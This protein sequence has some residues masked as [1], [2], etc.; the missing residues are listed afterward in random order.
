MVRKPSAGNRDDAGEGI[1]MTSA[2]RG[3]LADGEAG[4]HARMRGEKRKEG[5]V[6]VTDGGAGS[7]KP[8]K[9]Q[10]SSGRE[11][12]PSGS[13]DV[14]AAGD[15]NKSNDV[16]DKKFEGQR[17][18]EWSAEE[19][20]SLKNR[21]KDWAAAHGEL[22]NFEAGN[23]EFLFKRRQKQ[24]GR[25]A[26]LADSERKAFLEIAHGF[27]TR[28]PKQ[29]Y[30]FISR[31]YDS[32]NYKGK[33]TEEEKETLRT[34]TA[35]HGDKWKVIGAAMGRAGYACRDKW[36]MMKNSPKGGDWSSEEIAKL[37]ELVDEYFQQNSSAPGRGAGEGNEHLQVRDNINWKTIAMKLGTR[38][39][40]SCMQKWYR[41][42]PDGIESGQWGEGQDKILIEAVIRS[43]AESEVDVPWG[44]LVPG[45][46]LS[47]IKRR[48]KQLKQSIV[49]PNGGSFDDM[50]KK[51]K[52]KY[53][54][55]LALPAAG[56]L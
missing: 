30:G 39:E 15:R 23:F 21:I 51:M 42:S 53:C 41:I 54:G 56:N 52:E 7:S 22:T 3:S 19:K 32:T 40:N 37:R 11:L 8:S 28:N 34:L 16:W 50:M 27:D 5:F 2:P 14:V 12:A 44:D 48:F 25:G 38:N 26:K 20:D 45:R 24:G 46:T 17:F 55:S 29:I 1:Q 4:D 47:Q 49:D 36:R 35:E 43:G 10:K 31:H 9:K 18:G 13:G 33:W 6:T